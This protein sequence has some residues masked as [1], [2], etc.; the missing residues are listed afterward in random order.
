MKDLIEENLYNSL[1]NKLLVVAFNMDKQNRFRLFFRI[2]NFL[3]I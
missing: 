2:Q 3:K 1:A